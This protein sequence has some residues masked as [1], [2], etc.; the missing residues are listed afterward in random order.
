MLLCAQLSVSNCLA[1]SI[2]MFSTRS[3][4]VLWDVWKFISF[5][6]VLLYLTV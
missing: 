1:V 2:C 5:S 4:G 3:L 6:D